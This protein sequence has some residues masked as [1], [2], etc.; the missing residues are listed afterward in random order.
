MVKAV[1][2]IAHRVKG[3]LMARCSLNRGST[4]ENPM[5]FRLPQVAW[6]FNTPDLD[7]SGYLARLDS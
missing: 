5:T 3:Y 6:L 4:K 7:V 2:L 1:T